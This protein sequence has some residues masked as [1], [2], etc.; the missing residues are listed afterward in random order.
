ME[1]RII[2]IF[3]AARTYSG[4]RYGYNRSSSQIT[5]LFDDRSEADFVVTQRRG[6]AWMEDAFALLAKEMVVNV[7]STH[8][9]Y[10]YLKIMG[11]NLITDCCQVNRIKHLHR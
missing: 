8:F 6:T 2:A 1:K 7:P 9:R 5:I 11:I 10:K 4:D 3:I